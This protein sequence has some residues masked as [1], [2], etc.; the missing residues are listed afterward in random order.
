MYNHVSRKQIS[1]WLDG[2]L[3]PKAMAS[4]GRHLD[5]CPVCRSA[6]DEMFEVDRAFRQTAVLE[7]PER[8]WAEISS[9]LSRA[10]QSPA[11]RFSTVG[12]V[13]GRPAWLR[14]DVWALAA[15]LLFGCS[16]AIVHWSSAYKERQRLAQIDR[17]YRNLLP[18]NAESFNPF[19]ASPLNDVARNPFTL[20]GRNSLAKP[21]SKPG[22]K[23]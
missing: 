2:Q 22:V 16:L 7:P 18:P 15:T 20:P 21:S 12:I 11:G 14:A 19:T 23:R 9:S 4:I 6:R 8:L 3:R 13:A 5:Q 10:G 17:A 1:S